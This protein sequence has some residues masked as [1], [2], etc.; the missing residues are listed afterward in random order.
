ML[1]PWITSNQMEDGVLKAG[2]QDL[3]NMQSI[4]IFAKEVTED[5]VSK[6]VLSGTP[7]D[8][9][10]D[11]N[12]L[13]G[14]KKPDYTLAKSEDGMVF[15]YTVTNGYQHGDWRIKKCTNVG[16]KYENGRFVYEERVFDNV[17]FELYADE[18]ICAG[19]TF[20][21]KADT[22]IT[23]EVMNRSVWASGGKHNPSMSLI[24]RFR[25]ED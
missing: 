13:S 23:Q 5:K 15:T 12:P 11:D 21:W 6:I 24:I 8:G 3:S 16:I 22:K 17:V 10:R 1:L 19:D 7:P 2:M 14:S 18:D 9:W 20:L 4:P 25:R